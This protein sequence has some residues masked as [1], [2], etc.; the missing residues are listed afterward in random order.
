MLL[1]LVPSLLVL[2]ASLGLQWFVYE[3]LL[4]RT[5]QWRVTGSA[6]ATILT[7]LFL[8]RWKVAE[9]ERQREMQQRLDIIREMNDRIRN[10]LQIIEV[11]SYVSQPNATAPIREAIEVID[12]A[13]RE[14]SAGV[15][16]AE[17]NLSEK[18]T[19]LDLS[20]R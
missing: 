14:G 20:A 11:T 19:E 3:H 17:S 1:A 10:A 13:L 18:T 5:G 2:V 15:A 16:S 8:C 12:A 7:F 6:L 9:R 4:H